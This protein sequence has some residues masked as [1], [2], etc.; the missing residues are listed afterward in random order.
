MDVREASELIRH[1]LVV[2]LLISSPI[3]L[4]GLIVG[5]IVSL[6]QAVTQIQEQ[7]ISFVPKT[8]AMV[9][10]AIFLMPWISHRLLEYTTSVFSGM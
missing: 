2:A 7:A 9:A 10:A 8:V 3:L 5:L 4:I 1:T 6:V